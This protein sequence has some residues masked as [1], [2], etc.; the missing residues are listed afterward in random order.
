MSNY[1]FIVLY[2]LNVLN[3]LNSNK[4][5][6]HN[7]SPFEDK[8]T[9]G[10]D[11]TKDYLTTHLEK[12]MKPAFRHRD[13]DDSWSRVLCAIAFVIEKNIIENTH[14]EIEIRLTES[15]LIRLIL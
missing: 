5:P 1:L 13:S 10:S 3:L 15:M 8:K 14:V 12:D 4:S 11:H 7:H 9:R 2:S 6:E